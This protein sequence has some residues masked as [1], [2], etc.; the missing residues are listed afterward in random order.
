MVSTRPCTGE[1][2]EGWGMIRLPE[3]RSEPY[4]TIALRSEI[5][6]SNPNLAGLKRLLE[7]QG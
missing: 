1:G 5:S 2:V 3:Y 7:E 6:I 4:A